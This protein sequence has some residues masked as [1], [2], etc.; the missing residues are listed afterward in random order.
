MIRGTW[1]SAARSTAIYPTVVEISSVVC[2]SVD[3]VSFIWDL[4]LLRNPIDLAKMI[5]RFE[6]SLFLD[7]IL[8]DPA[9]VLCRCHC[10]SHLLIT[11]KTRAVLSL[12]R[13][14]CHVASRWVWPQEVRHNKQELS[15]SNFTPMHF[16]RELLRLEPVF[17]CFF[18]KLLISFISI[19]KYLSS[20]TIRHHFVFYFHTF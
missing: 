12:G 17:V 8:H 2:P 5:S 20:K 3:F 4:T 1:V 19:K 18:T 10:L 9:E 6:S 15:G 16:Y 13:P 7:K 11:C 14:V